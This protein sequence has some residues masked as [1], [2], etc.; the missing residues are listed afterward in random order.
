MDEFR[1]LSIRNIAVSSY[2]KFPLKG[3]AFTISWPPF[4]D[5]AYRTLDGSVIETLLFCCLLAEATSL[6]KKRTTK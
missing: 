2:S 5:Q 1:Q 6:N 4:S 3:R